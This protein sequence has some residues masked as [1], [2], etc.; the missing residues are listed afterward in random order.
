[1]EDDIPIGRFEDEKYLIW[2]IFHS[3]RHN[4]A[5]YGDMIS[6]YGILDHKVFLLYGL[7]EWDNILQRYS[8]FCYLTWNL[9]V[10][11]RKHFEKIAF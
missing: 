4:L 9:R 6:L 10:Q 3:L 5:G 2:L 8:Y 7:L 11:K 1:M